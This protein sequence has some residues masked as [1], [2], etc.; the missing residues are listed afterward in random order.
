M[1]DFKPKN[2]D[3]ERQ[4]RESFQRQKFIVN[5][6]ARL[7]HV[8]PG[9]VEIE[10]PFNENLTQQHGFLH[11]GA[12]TAVVDSACG[13]AALSLMPAQSAVL[14]VEYKINM[15]APAIGESIIAKGWVIKPG[16]NIIVCSGEALASDKGGNKIVAV[17]QGTM[18]VVRDR[19]QLRD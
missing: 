3:Y 12:I 2:P 9:R 13:Y 19:P 17:M 4:I 1:S 14:S 5:M 10:L 6:G 18:A 16:R 8:S 7:S 15:L 11:A